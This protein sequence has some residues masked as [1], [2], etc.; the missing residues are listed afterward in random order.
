MTKVFSIAACTLPYKKDR[1]EYFA[2][3]VTEYTLEELENL[4]AL[5]EELISSTPDESVMRASVDTLISAVYLDGRHGGTNRVDAIR[6]YGYLCPK[7]ATMKTIVNTMPKLQLLGTRFMTNIEAHLRA[8]TVHDRTGHF[9]TAKPCIDDAELIDF[10]NKNPEH[11]EE[12]MRHKLSRNG[13]PYSIETM[14]EVAQLGAVRDGW[15]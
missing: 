12:I 4:D 13:V 14:L 7:V 10:I 2:S 11:A 6:D 1:E 9:C 8:A 3:F 5:I 15:L